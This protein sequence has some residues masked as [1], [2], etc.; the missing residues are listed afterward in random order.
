MKHT[1]AFDLVL[2]SP[3]TNQVGPFLNITTQAGQGLPRGVL[4]LQGPSGS[5]KGGLWL[6][7]RLL[8]ERTRREI[9]EDAG[10]WH[11]PGSSTLVEE[12]QEGS[13]EEVALE[14]GRR[15]AGRRVRLGRR[16]LVQ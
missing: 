11:L 14:A 15:E 13:M 1:C 7:V 9:Q 8:R 5:R 10:L 4:G 2:S 6:I 12:I 16:E 3:D